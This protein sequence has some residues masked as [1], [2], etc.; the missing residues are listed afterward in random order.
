L[1]SNPSSDFLPD[2]ITQDLGGAFHNPIGIPS[3]QGYF[4]ADYETP[5]FPHLPRTT[6]RVALA[7]QVERQ[8]ALFVSAVEYHTI[9]PKSHPQLYGM[10][11]LNALQG[12][13]P[14]PPT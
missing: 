12:S 10:N 4:S 5:D 1:L 7:S 2:R 14:N 11:V 13:A 3:I 6:R 9:S 8:S